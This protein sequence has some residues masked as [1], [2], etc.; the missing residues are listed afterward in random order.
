MILCQSSESVSL[1]CTP[2]PRSAMTIVSNETDIGALGTLLT[3]WD[4]WGV[5]ANTRAEK[6]GLRVQGEGGWAPTSHM[7]SRGK[8]VT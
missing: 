2:T 8:D 3:S 6:M 4:N 7:C 1:F 5:I